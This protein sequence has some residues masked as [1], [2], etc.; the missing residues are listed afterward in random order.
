[1]SDKF[2]QSPERIY[3]NKKGRKFRVIT[4]RA[5]VQCPGCRYDPDGAGQGAF[6]IMWLD[7]NEIEFLNREEID[8]SEPVS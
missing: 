7:N 2:K 5:K 3:R 8:H 1:M 4:D 6:M